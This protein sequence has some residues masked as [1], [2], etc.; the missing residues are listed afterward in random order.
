[1]KV[2]RATIS[3]DRRSQAATGLDP[4]DPYGLAH[5]GREVGAVDRAAIQIAKVLHR[6]VMSIVGCRPLAGCSCSADT[7]P[8]ASLVAALEAEQQMADATRN[9]GRFD[10]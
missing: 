5:G 3:A 9:A 7:H 8:C 6:P 4:T 10:A 2:T 1:M